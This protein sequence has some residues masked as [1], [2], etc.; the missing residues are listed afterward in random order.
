MRSVENR[1]SNSIN[2][3]LFDNAR[4]FFSVTTN[5]GW[6]I[7]GE[8]LKNALSALNSSEKH[9][10]R[11]FTLSNKW[12]PFAWS[13]NY[14]ES[15]RVL[16]PILDPHVAFWLASS[17]VRREAQQ[18]DVI[19]AATAPLA[20]AFLVGKRHPYVF[21][22][23]DGT[24][25]I[26]R[27]DF[28]IDNV[29]DAAIE[30][31]RKHF[32][33]VQHTF[34]LSNWVKRNIVDVYGVPANRVTVV[35]PLAQSVMEQIPKR[36]RNKRLQIA[37]VGGDFIRKGGQNLIAW[38]CQSLHKFADLHVVTDPRWNDSS[39]PATRWYGHL[40]NA[41]IVDELLP[42]VDVLCHPTTR[43]CSAI[44]VA[45][46]AA[47]GVPSVASSVGG[48]PDLIEHNK[49]G[50]LASWADGRAFINHLEQLHVDREL[51]EQMALAV[52]EKARADFSP[53]RVLQMIF[54]SVKDALK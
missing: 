19:V 43:D 5:L 20:S 13:A 37:F 38:Q 14:S 25:D 6:K 16:F 41:K 54:A 47:L 53:E 31:E 39:V 15:E 34:A 40:S 51:L 2:K 7:M 30:R 11:A 33:Q 9:G 42:S 45:E 36:K 22:F 48:I 8:R 10:F 24:R 32:H 35:P 3:L 29:S 49:T 17:A 52:H 1:Q 4:L 18:Y 46:A 21:Q 50:F 12:S 44:V 27:R 23:V 28:G 26:F